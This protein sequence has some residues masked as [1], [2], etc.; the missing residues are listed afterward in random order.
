[1]GERGGLIVKPQ[2]AYRELKGYKY[3]L[4]E[5]Y[6]IRLGPEF[7]IERRIQH[8]ASAAAMEEVIVVEGPLK[9]G[10]AL[11]IVRKG[12]AWDGPSGPT[13]DTKNFMRGSLVHDALYQ[14]MREGLLS[15][16]L[17]DE[18]DKLLRRI[19]I[20]DGMSAVRAWIVYQGVHRFASFAVAAKAE[21]PQ[22]RIVVA[23]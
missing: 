11:L 15:R 19:C 3:Q 18:A 8:P 4:A 16:D 20:E 23:P 7:N 6:R 12:Y 1:M 17:R 10:E 14:L 5:T 22:D 13:V 2:I 21:E 9:D